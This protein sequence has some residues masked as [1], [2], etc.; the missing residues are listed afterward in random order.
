M[1]AIDTEKFI[2]KYKIRDQAVHMKTYNLI[3]EFF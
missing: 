1:C 3:L 2:Y